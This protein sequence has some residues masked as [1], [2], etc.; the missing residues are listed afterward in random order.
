MLV[1]MPELSTKLASMVNGAR[2]LLFPPGCLFCRKVLDESDGCC[3]DCLQEILIWPVSTCMRCGSMLPQAV[4]PGPCGHCLHHLPAQQQ[5]HSLY[6]YHGP[7]RDAILSWKLAGQDAGVRWLL[8]AAI[9]SL[10]QLITPDDLLLPIP[11][12]LSRMRKSGQHHAA[13][14]CRWLAT[15]TGSRLEWR[16]LR[17]IGEQ[18]RQ[19][20][21]S[22]VARRKNLCKAFGLCD[23]YPS[24]TQ[25]LSPH[26]RLW[27]VDDIFTT[28]STVHYAARAAIKTKLPVHVLTL[29]RTRHQGS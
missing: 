15:S 21:L 2:H 5:T 29:A 12:P 4:A 1:G 23:D 18:P 8:Q 14:L 25:A 11:A 22:G 10:Q 19:S 7:V 6:Q 17:R 3:P 27:I 13:N 26:A 28:G 24:I 20:A 9:P 16:L